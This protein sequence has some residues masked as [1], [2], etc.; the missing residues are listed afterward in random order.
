MYLFVF[1]NHWH[2]KLKLSLERPQLCLMCGDRG[3]PMCRP[4]GGR[5]G[6]GSCCP[7]L[8]LFEFFP[9]HRGPKRKP[10]T[11][12]ILK[13]L[14]EHFLLAPESSQ[15]GSSWCQTFSD[16]NGKV[17][18]RKCR[19]DQSLQCYR[20][21]CYHVSVVWWAFSRK[22][23]QLYGVFPV[24]GIRPAQ[25]CRNTL[26]D[27]TGD[28]LFPLRDSCGHLLPFAGHPSLLTLL[29]AVL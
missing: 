3:D 12:L 25:S 22:M 29:W 15:V 11:R 4:V 16:K 6:W 19:M 20:V 1:L 26:L 8:A 21:S 28:F 23:S 5:H 7:R 13:R 27:P 17:I 24:S 2:C 14:S 9:G 10:E 18:S